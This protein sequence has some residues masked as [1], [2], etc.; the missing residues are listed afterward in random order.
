MKKIVFALSA[1]VACV[2]FADLKIAVV[3]MPDLVKFHHTH[4]YN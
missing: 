4:E 1:A 3:N 2:A